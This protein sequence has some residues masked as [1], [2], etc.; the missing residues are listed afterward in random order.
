MTS[1]FTAPPGQEGKV[2]ALIAAIALMTLAMAFMLGM[3]VGRLLSPGGGPAPAAVDAA[4]LPVMAITLPP[5]A[6]PLR[7]SVGEG[8]LIVSYEGPRGRGAV[9]APAPSRPTH[10]VYVN[11]A[12]DGGAP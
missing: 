2:R 8:A 9:V 5:G 7:E 3:I 10:I 6:A 4:G 12:S 11:A 1:L